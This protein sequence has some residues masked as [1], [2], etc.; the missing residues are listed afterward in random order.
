LARLVELAIIKHDL[1]KFLPSFQKRLGNKNYAFEVGKFFLKAPHSLVSILFQLEG[2]EILVEIDKRILNSV[3]AYHHYRDYFDKLITSSDS[4]IHQTAKELLEDTTWR[5]E[6]LKLL[7]RETNRKIDVDEITVRFLSNGGSISTIAP[8]PYKMK[9]LLHREDLPTEKQLLWLLLAGILQRVD[10]F[11]SFLEEED[12]K[13]EDED[14]QIEKSPPAEERII[15]KI[16]KEINRKGGN[17]WQ[18]EL[19]ENKNLKEKKLTI[20]I[21]PTGSGK[22]EFAILWGAGEKL[23]YTL[24]LRSAVNQIFSRFEKIYGEE[25]VGLLHSDAD[26][27]LLEERIKDIE[28][29]DV[30]LANALRTYETARHLSYPAIVSTGDQFFPYALKPP[31]YERIY[32]TALTSAFVIDEIQAYDPKAMAIATRFIEEIVSLGG[33]ALIITATFPNFIKEYLERALGENSIDIINLY[34]EFKEFFTQ[35]KKHRYQF[36]RVNENLESEELIKKIIEE[37]QK[38]KR[39]LVV[40]NTIKDADNLYQLLDEKIEEDMKLFKFH[41]EMTLSERKELEEELEKRFSNPKPSSEKKGKILVATQV[42]EASL[43]IDADILFT[44]LAPL[45]A[46]VQRMGRVARRYSFRINSFERKDIKVIDK[47]TNRDYEIARNQDFKAVEE[48]NN[49]NPNVF[50]L[51]KTKKKGGKWKFV[52]D[53]IYSDVLLDLTFLTLTGEENLSQKDLIKLVEK[54]LNQK[55]LEKKVIDLSEY[56]KQE[57]L[58][59]IFEFLESLNEK[60]YLEEFYKTIEILSGG[61]FSEHRAEAQRIF[62]EVY[63]VLTLKEENLEEFKGDLKK[64]V[65]NHWSKS[66]KGLYTLF[67]KEVIAK[68]LIPMNLWKAQNKYRLINLADLISEEILPQNLS[69][70]EKEEEK[71]KK[72]KRWLRRL[73]GWLHNVFLLKNPLP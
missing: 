22:T 15:Q 32:V 13:G 63:S 46:L 17:L 23:L 5:E 31:L 49:G 18:Q 35:F 36:L 69:E 50:I 30:A 9:F 11:A 14:L 62:R 51:I 2:E 72:K 38:G 68:Y 59:K 16:E 52:K 1:G 43:D 73:K 6:V 55:S 70:E 34:E 71:E 21:A 40:V 4:D 33:R 44:T 61:Y 28:D 41:S 27:Y 10:H 26:L 24:P 56:E 12:L 58:N 64:F 25:N 20:L 37:A 60:T 45:D 8:P 57:K 53:R 39:V 19:I 3:V 54:K 67:K 47:S 66:G 42:V 7:Q 29:E 48:Y 65:E